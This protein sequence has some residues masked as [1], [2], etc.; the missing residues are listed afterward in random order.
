M[1]YTDYNT[2]LLKWIFILCWSFSLF[3]SSGLLVAETDSK[4]RLTETEHQ[5]LTEHPVIRVSNEKDWAPF[6]F[7][8]KGQPAGYSIELFD[9]VAE[10]LGVKFEYI[11]DMTWSQ[12]LG[13]FKKGEIDVMSAIY[14][15]ESRKAFSL[16][17]Q[18]YFKNPPAII[19]HK[20]ENRIQKLSDLSGM[21]VALP[22]DF[23]LFE[24]ISQEVPDVIMLKEIDG[25]PIETTLD[26]LKAVVAGKADAVVESAATLTYQIELNGLPN[27]K[28]AGYPEFHHVD[29]N[30]FDLYA[31]V[32]K[33]WPVFHGILIKALNIITAEER[34]ALQK[35]WLGLTAVSELSKLN[36]T[37]QEQAYLAR[38]SEIRYCIDPNWMPYESIDADGRHI[39]MTSEFIQRL[40]ERI[41]VPFR[42]TPTSSWFESLQQLK[43]G[44]V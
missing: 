34:L 37:F 25:R 39:G 30:D 14:I 18:P 4:L 12:L 35:K 3:F 38:K 8:E 36:L 22:K 17:T 27:L 15:S 29:V 5:W 21:R 31:A 44:G 33:D 32:R 1:Y 19:T 23:A 9:R 28:I 13:A 2:S 26:A 20:N 7:M 40:E 24:T 42:L 43:S 16:F 11:N 41:G 10:I 6:D